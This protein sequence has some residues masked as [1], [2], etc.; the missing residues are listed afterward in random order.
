[1]VCNTLITGSNP[2][3]ASKESSKD[4]SFFS[5]ESLGLFAMEKKGVL[6]I[7]ESVICNTP[8]WWLNLHYFVW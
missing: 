7:Y 8:F 5:V 6:Q 1:M 3:R 2:V 4:G